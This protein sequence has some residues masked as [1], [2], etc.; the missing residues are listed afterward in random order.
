VSEQHDARLRNLSRS[1]CL[2]LLQQ[3]QV[4]RIGYVVD[5]LAVI[6]PVNFVLFHEDIVFCTA[7]GGTLAWLSTR[8]RVAFEVDESRS[9]D[10]EGWSVLVHGSA[11]EVTDPGQLEALRGSP[12][13]SWVRSPDDHWVRIRI[14][15]ISGR[16]VHGG[17]N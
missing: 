5:G 16:S 6:L 7:K 14:E 4:G 15:A 17:G 12:L 2:V 13:R 9:A 3:A 11:S 10:Q 1:E 8:Q